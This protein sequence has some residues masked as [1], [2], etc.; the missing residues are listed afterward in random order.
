[1]EP[2]RI[3][4]N[5]TYNMV[6][7]CTLLYDYKYIMS[8][9]VLKCKTAPYNIRQY[10][11]TSYIV[12]YYDMVKYSIPYVGTVPDMPYIY[13]YIYIIDIQYVSKYWTSFWSP[14]RSR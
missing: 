10:H 13:I 2:D 4:Y 6:R 5:A 12:M 11:I 1:M 9:C 7:Y 3:E 14:I 8:H